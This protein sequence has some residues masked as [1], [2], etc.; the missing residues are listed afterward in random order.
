MSA[1]TITPID[2]MKEPA[3]FRKKYVKFPLSIYRSK[4]YKNEP[5]AKA[6]VAPFIVDVM[7][8]FDVKK[9][10]KLHRCDI[11]SFI[12]ERDGKVVGRITAIISHAHLEE[13]NDNT[14]HFGYCDFIDDKE[15]SKALFDTA[16]AWLKERGI[17]AMS[18]P[19]NFTINC[20]LGDRK[21]VV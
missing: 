20:E 4:Q 16:A 13:Y 5:W 3:K 17:T 14:G 10:P 15:V 21:S 2:R 9:N 1:I 18:G 6:W 7:T 12:A 19:F 11:Q 8:R